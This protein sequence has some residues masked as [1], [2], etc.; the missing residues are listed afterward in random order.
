M[1]GEDPRERRQRF[2]GAILVIPGKED[3]VLA[4]ARPFGPF[5][6]DQI[7]GQ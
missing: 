5:L 6:I 4:F 3:D 1:L 2:L 7:D